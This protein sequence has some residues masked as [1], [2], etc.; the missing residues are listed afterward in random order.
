MGGVEATA[1]IMLLV[2]FLGGVM[3][4]IIVIV[5]V[6]SRREDRR[7]SLTGEAPGPASEGARW[8]TGVGV[9]GDQF[10]S[11]GLRRGAG[12]NEDAHG[13]ELDQ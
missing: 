1:V 10:V 13:R 2:G 5:S 9:R 12:Q 11:A 7:H 3:V 4:G 6:A 8:L